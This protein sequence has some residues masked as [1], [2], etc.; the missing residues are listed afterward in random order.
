MSGSVVS[1]TPGSFL[2]RRALFDTSPAQYPAGHGGRF[3]PWYIGCLG[4]ILGVTSSENHRCLMRVRRTLLA[5]LLAA[6]AGITPVLSP[7]KL[8]EELM[9]ARV[10]ALI[11]VRS[12]GEW[13]EGHLGAADLVESMH[14]NKDVSS[15]KGCEEC[16]IVTYCHSGMRASISAK[17]LLDNGFKNVSNG[18]GIKQ[19]EDAGY[20]LVSGSSIKP[21]CAGTGVC[22]PVDFKYWELLKELKELNTLSSSSRPLLSPRASPATLPLLAAAVLAGIAMAATLS[23]R[24]P[25]KPM[26]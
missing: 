7:A 22:S 13:E 4:V 9:A 20:R 17:I 14:V 24:T 6:C 26:L 11:D 1:V 5:S 3:L 10:D 12:L 25:G 18:L 15:L 8:Y 23:T 2:L 16:R 19:W 21:S